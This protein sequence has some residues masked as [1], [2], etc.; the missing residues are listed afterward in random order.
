[1]RE[2]NKEKAKEKI[3]NSKGKI[4]YCEFHKRSNGENRPMT[5][6]LHVKSH[7][8]DGEKSY[9]PEEKD[10]ITVFDMDKSAYRSINVPG[11][12]ELHAEGEEFKV[13]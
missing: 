11:L 6:R 7:L 12:H 9:D 4:F 1:M 10:L 5:A 2:I 8:K 13:N 3:L